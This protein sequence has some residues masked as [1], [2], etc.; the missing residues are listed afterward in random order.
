MTIGTVVPSTTE[1]PLLH[2]F[3][4]ITIFENYTV[5]DFEKD[6]IKNRMNFLTNDGDTRRWLYYM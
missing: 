1:L 4:K 5:G 2:H 6:A 3:P